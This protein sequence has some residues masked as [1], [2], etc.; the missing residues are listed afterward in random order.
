MNRANNIDIRDA[1]F[2]EIYNIAAKDKNVIFITADADAFSLRKYKK[3]FPGQFINVGVAEQNMIVVAVGLALSGKKVFIYAL[4]P[5]IALRCYEHIKTNICGMNLPI[6]II[7][8]G[9]GFSF[10][11]D[12]PTH[13][14]IQ[15]IAVM[16]TLP[17][18][19]ILNPSDIQ[20]AAVFARLVYQSSAPAY[21]RL[22]KGIRP[23]IYNNEND[24]SPGLSTI[25]SGSDLCIISTGIM[26]YRAQEVADELAKHNINA[27][28]VD[29]YMLKPVNEKLL[30]E[31]LDKYRAIV[32]L[33]ENAI[34]GGIGSIISEVL[35]DN[36]RTMPL[37]R[38]ASKDEQCFYYGTRDWIHGIN[39]IDIENVLKGIQIWYNK[40]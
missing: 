26:I 8:A 1:F 16:R 40:L 22:D 19:T 27:G 6:T 21:I 20:S 24:F 9:A 33:E 4:I 31:V 10:E 32:T 38:F 36:Q 15:D 17:E 7:G 37:L 13:H 30:L 2:D 23:A 12:G 29:F 25:K 11:N 5:F 28:I 14:A 35:T 34:T 18:M 3:D 39:K